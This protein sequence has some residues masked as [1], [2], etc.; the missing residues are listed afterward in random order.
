M[1]FSISLR[2]SPKPGALTAATF[3]HAAQ[4]VDDERGERLAFEVLGDDEQRLAGRAPS[5][6]HGSSSC[7]LEIFFS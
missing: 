1:S 7:M 6:E 3:R 2:R 5:L 4:A